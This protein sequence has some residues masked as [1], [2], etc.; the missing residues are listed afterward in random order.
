MSTSGPVD[1][2]PSQLQRFDLFR[3]IKASDARVLARGFLREEFTE[4]EHVFHEGESGDKLY[5]IVEG[6]VRISQPLLGGSREEALAILRAGQFFGDM[7]LIDARP[8]SADAIA[9]E[10]CVLYSIDRSAFTMMLQVNGPLAID[11]LFQFMRS[12]CTR[13]RDNNEKVRALNSMA[14]W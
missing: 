3:S 8:R 5:L 10:R 14:M 4:G 11:V 12:L 1:I 2:D 6:A 13:L 7:S 9:H